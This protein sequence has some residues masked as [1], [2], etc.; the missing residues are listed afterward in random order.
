MLVSAA[1]II[2]SNKEGH[3]YILQNERPCNWPYRNSMSYSTP[4]WEKFL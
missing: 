1:N 2:G 4:V 3:L